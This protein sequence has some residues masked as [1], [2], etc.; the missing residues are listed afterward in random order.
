MM[1]LSLVSKFGR[2]YAVLAVG[3]LGLDDLRSIISFLVNFYYYSAWYP[4]LAGYIAA[5]SYWRTK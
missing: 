2:Y 1:S 4:L 5:N 3:H